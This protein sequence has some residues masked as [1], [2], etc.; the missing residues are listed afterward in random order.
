MLQPWWSN[1]RSNQWS[2]Q[3]SKHHAARQ[4]QT[5][6]TGQDVETLAATY[7]ARQHRRVHHTKGV[8]RNRAPYSWSVPAS[9][10]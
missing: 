2:N 9:V 8:G 7:T 5:A 1:Q 6:A 4:N 10:H 3:R